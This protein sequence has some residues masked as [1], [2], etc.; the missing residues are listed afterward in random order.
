MKYV[1]S[2]FGYSNKMFHKSN[3]RVEIYIL[4]HNLQLQFFMVGKIRWWEN[5]AFHIISAGWR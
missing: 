1:S 3:L 4:Y 5:D 2:F